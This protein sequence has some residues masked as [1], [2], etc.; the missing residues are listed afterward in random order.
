MLAEVTQ[1]IATCFEGIISRYP[2]QWYNFFPSW[3]SA[4]EGADDGAMRGDAA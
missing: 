4:P 3:V 2:D 1:R